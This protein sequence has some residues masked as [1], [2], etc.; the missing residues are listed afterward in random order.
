MKLEPELLQASM[1][2]SDMDLAEIFHK[3]IMIRLTEEE[4]GFVSTVRYG[5]FIRRSSTWS[6]LSP[7]ETAWGSLLRDGSS[8][9][10][11]SENG[12]AA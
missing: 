6:V 5:P 1:K 2:G 4:D 10:E 12:Q 8:S 9:I 7:E 11:N 3:T